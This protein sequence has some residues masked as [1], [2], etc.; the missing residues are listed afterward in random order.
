MESK[1]IE[2]LIKRIFAMNKTILEMLEEIEGLL[3]CIRADLNS[4]FHDWEDEI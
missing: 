1:E 4:G 2:M 3:R